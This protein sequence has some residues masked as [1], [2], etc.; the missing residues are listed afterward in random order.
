MN[1]DGNLRGRKKEG[2]FPKKELTLLIVLAAIQFTSIVD[3]VIMM[4]LGPQY[5]SVFKITP[6]QFGHVVS[7]YGLSAGVA[8]IL[9]GL[10]LDRLDRKKALLW[11]YAGFGA[12]TLCCAVAP[13]YELLAAA[14][15]VAGA[16]GG[17]TGAVIMAIIGD[18]IPESRRGAAMGVV[19]SAFSLASVFGVPA[20]LFLA[21]KFGW[22]APFFMLAGLSALILAAAARALPRMDHHVAGSLEVAAWPFMKDLLSQNS[23]LL[24]F[25]FMALLTFASFFINP[26]LSTYMVSNT[27][28]RQSD[29]GLMYMVG[30]LAT[31]FTMNWVGRWSDRAGKR[32]VFIVMALASVVPS[33]VLTRLA[34]TPLVVSLG[35][36]TLYMICMSGRMVPA[37][38]ML[39]STVATR[40]RGSFMSLNAS[41][42]H[43]S[44]GLAADAAGRVLLA[45]K[46]TGRLL[47]FDWLGIWAAGLTVAGVLMSLKLKTAAKVSAAEGTALAAAEG[48][49]LM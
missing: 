20:G 13:R 12:G 19:M 5:M 34:R 37:M 44:A 31:I 48:V 36:T 14:R 43:L 17:V 3:F 24:A 21:N 4:P 29:L 47:R 45:E 2:R 32:P 26:Y 28:F 7:A 35:W 22:H 16:F 10:F 1:T 33:L 18:A 9:A 41:V 8:G 46:G 49:E 39:T 15:A 11:V 38:A 42:Q 25:V 27:G 30:G 40:F 6:E 23:H